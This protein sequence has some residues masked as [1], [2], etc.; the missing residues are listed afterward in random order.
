MVLI[1]VEIAGGSHREVE[2]A[3]AGEQFQHVIEEADAGAHRIPA[4]A[5]EAD[6]QR[7]LRFGGASIDYRTAHR[8]SSI[9]AMPRRVCS[10]TPAAMRKQPPHPGSVERSRR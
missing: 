7:D 6:R 10:T 3:V 5:L 1:D 2:G 9:A 8:I 4:L